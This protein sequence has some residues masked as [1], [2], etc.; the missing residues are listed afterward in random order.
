MTLV[1]TPPPPTPS[2]P[3]SDLTWENFRSFFDFFSI[4]HIFFDHL[5]QFV[6]KNAAVL[7]YQT[8]ISTSG[9]PFRDIFIFLKSGPRFQFF[10]FNLK[11]GFFRYSRF[12]FDFGHEMTIHKSKNSIREHGDIDFSRRFR[13]W[14]RKNHTS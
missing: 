2:P 4:P 11:P 9:G 5:D 6:S 14:Q 8:S 13:K 10:L 1:T 3:G 12:F 7:S